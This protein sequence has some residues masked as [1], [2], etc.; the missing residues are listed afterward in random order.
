[1]ARQNPEI[2]SSILVGGALTNYHDEGQGFPLLMIHGSG[3]GVSAWANWRLAIP[4]LSRKRRVIA[5]DM[6]GFGFSERVPGVR[7]SMDGWVGQLVGL[8][9]ALDISQADLVGN[10]FG[11]ALALAMAIRHPDRVRRLVLMGSVGVPFEITPELDAVW[12]YAPSLVAMRRLLD[13]FAYDRTLVTDELARL[14]FE[15][16]IRPGF[17]ESFAAMFPA[18][19]QRWVDAM[20]QSEDDIR[21]ISH[22]TL[23]LHGRDDRVIP[24]ENSLILNRWI[25]RSQLHVFGCCGHWVQIEHAARFVRLVGDFLGEA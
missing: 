13:I 4:E 18:P 15:A 14:R 19:R 25:N 12:G 3:P 11:G 1:M 9:D 2:A 10:S 21:A 6:A 7:Y 5:P 16:S 23:I 20:A 24:L 8:M 17:Q 22:E